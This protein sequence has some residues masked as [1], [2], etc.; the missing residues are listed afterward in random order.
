MGEGPILSTISQAID[1]LNENPPNLQEFKNQV[2]EI[3]D[4]LSGNQHNGR[5]M[6]LSAISKMTDFLEGNVNY[7]GI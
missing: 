5:I 1:C 2:E 6:A 3:R 7:G 4:Q